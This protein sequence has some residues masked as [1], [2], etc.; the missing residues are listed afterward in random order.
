MDP[1]D[2]FSNKSWPT[3]LVES[4]QRNG[5]CV[6]VSEYSTECVCVHTNTGAAHEDN[7]E[8]LHDA[9]HP[10]NPCQSEEKNDTK[11]VLEARQVDSHQ[12]A[13]VG[14]LIE[15]G[16]EGGGAKR[17]TEGRILTMTFRETSV[18]NISID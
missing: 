7:Q 1:I 14:R 8:G 13:H 2:W 15:R 4:T 9:S 12:S 10:N 17:E 18:L 11:D 16:R 5:V 3:L 6:C